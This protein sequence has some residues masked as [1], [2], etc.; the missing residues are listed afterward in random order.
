M[1]T[2]VPPRMDGSSLK[3]ASIRAPASLPISGHQRVALRRAQLARRHNLR[4]ANPCCSCTQRAIGRGHLAQPAPMRSLLISTASRLRSSF[5]SPSFAFILSRIATFCTCGDGGIHKEL[6]Q[7]GAA[8]PGGQKIGQL[9]VD[10]RP[11]PAWRRSPHRERRGRNG[12]Q[13]LPLVLPSLAASAG[14]TTRQSAPDPSPAS[15]PVAWPPDRWPGRR[16]SGAS[17]AAPAR[18]PRQS[19]ARQTAQCASSP[20]QARP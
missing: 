5:C 2:T 12:K 9:A 4:L 19:P 13:R 3:L 11:C 10:A 17:R 15:E 1:R 6:A 18:Q 14:G 8:V 16:Q 20:L 7:L